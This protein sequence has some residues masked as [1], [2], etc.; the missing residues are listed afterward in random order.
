[1]LRAEK[2]PH[3]PKQIGVGS[4]GGEFDKLF[5][6]FVNQ[7]PVRL[8]MSFPIAKIVAL[9][10]VRFASFWKLGIDGQQPDDFM[11]L[12]EVQVSLCRQLIVPLEAV[13]MYDRF[14]TASVRISNRQSA[15][16]PS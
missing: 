12:V 8:H 9:E 10:L 2:H 14:H 11:Q 7:Q 4:R 3:S 13:G 15:H 6:N 16:Q 5:I 1:M